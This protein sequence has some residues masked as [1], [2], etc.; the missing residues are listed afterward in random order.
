MNKKEPDDPT[1]EII[2]DC[3]EELFKSQSKSKLCITHFLCGD[4][5]TRGAIRKSALRAR[6][7][8]LSDFCGSLSANKANDLH[9]E[10]LRDHISYLDRNRTFLSFVEKIFSE[11]R[12]IGFLQVVI[13]P[14]KALS[15]YEMKPQLLETDETDLQFIFQYGPSFADA[16]APKKLVLDYFGALYQGKDMDEDLWEHKFHLCRAEVFG[17]T[18]DKRQSEELQQFIKRFKNEEEQHL[19]W[20]LLCAVQSALLYFIAA[21]TKSNSGKLPEGTVIAKRLEGIEIEGEHAPISPIGIAVLSPLLTRRNGAFTISQLKRDKEKAKG[22]ITSLESDFLISARDKIIRNHTSDVCGKIDPRFHEDASGSKSTRDDFRTKIKEL[23]LLPNQEARAE[24]FSLWMV[25]LA[26][27]LHKSVHEGHRLD[28]WL[29]AGDQT[30][31]AD[32]PSIVFKPL[33]RDDVNPLFVPKEDDNFREKIRRAASFLEKEHFPWFRRGRYALF[34]DVGGSIHGPTGLVAIKGSN[35]EQVVTETY[36]VKQ[37]LLIPA[38]C[39]V[40]TGGVPKEAGVIKC[41]GDEDLSISSSARRQK[42]I[43]GKHRSNK[44]PDVPRFSKIL[45]WRNGE[46]QRSS[47]DRSKR[48]STTLKK[49]LKASPNTRKD[50]DSIA[51]ICLLVADNPQAGGTIVFVDEKDFLELFS[52]M[53]KPWPIDESAEDKVALISHDGATL[54]HSS[55]K[56]WGYRFLLTPDDVNPEIKKSLVGRA[57]D[58]TLD[59]P[60][61]GVGSRRWSASLASFNEKV[62]AVIVISQ[63]GDIQCWSSKEMELN[64]QTLFGSLPQGGKPKKFDFESNQWKD[65]EDSIEQ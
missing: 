39:L 12:K 40:Y 24:C 16:L 4:K 43:G 45:R 7:S 14:N 49:L 9:H 31:F 25:W 61:T 8:R 30:E 2:E 32:H 37:Q 29:V 60:L 21:T 63:D 22:L 56:K 50:L 52:R 65:W 58:L 27:W 1:Q 23:F 53:G 57:D 5:S 35:W 59:F 6:N 48:L 64:K 15:D 38:C 17:R 10:V 54:I 18:A 13:I 34:W 28:F 11:D 47:D 44:S 46:W 62:R 33:D 3:A 55:L 41:I 26:E 36:K 42:I 20:Y 51:E 19:W